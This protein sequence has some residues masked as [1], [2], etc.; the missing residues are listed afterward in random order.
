ML[1]SVPFSLVPLVFFLGKDLKIVKYNFNFVLKFLFLFGFL[2][3]PL[4]YIA[5]LELYARIMIPV[6]LFILFIPHVKFRWKILIIGVAI[7]SVLFYLGFR[8]NILK[9]VFSFSLLGLY[10]FRKTI[11]QKIF[12]FGAIILFVLPF[13]LIF[14]GLSNR[15][16]VF[17]YLSE[18]KSYYTESRTGGEE[19]LI[20]DT[21]TFLY[22]EVLLSIA[23]TGNWLI[24]AS[25]SGSYQ[26]LWFWNNGGAMNGKRY[27]SEVGILNILLYDGILGVLIYFIL[28]F[29]VS[30][31]AINNSNNYLSKILGLFIAFRWSVSFI[32]EFTKYDLNFYFFW[33]AVGLVSSATFRNKSDKEIKDFF[34]LI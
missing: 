27:G 11:S 2:L 3:I 6:N 4:S 9:V 26:S 31:V 14:L 23:Q 32:E 21:R 18:Q 33:L 7:T 29:T 22:K 28:L 30:F 12:S 5:S 25:A 34:K 20:S 17:E 10:Y 24:G 13:I 16:N 8:T 19:N 1:S 15:F